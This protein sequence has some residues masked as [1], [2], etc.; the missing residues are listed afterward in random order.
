VLGVKKPWRMGRPP[1]SPPKRSAATSR[2]PR[3]R[4]LFRSRHVQ[5]PV[6]QGLRSR[7]PTVLVPC[8]CAGRA[9]GPPNPTRLDRRRAARSGWPQPRSRRVVACAQIEAEPGPICDDSRQRAPGRPVGRSE[10]RQNASSPAAWASGSSSTTTQAREPV[11]GLA[12]PPTR[13][14]PAAQRL[15]FGFRGAGR[16]RIRRQQQA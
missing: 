5:Q 1:E 7:Q 4:D 14:Q 10:P 16:R 13:E 6:E 9:A 2:Q 15:G 8:R 11:G 12:H 3:Y